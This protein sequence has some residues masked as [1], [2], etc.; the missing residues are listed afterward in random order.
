MRRDL[1]K[2]RQTWPRYFP[3]KKLNAIDVRVNA[4]DPNWPII[5]V[6]GPIHVNPKF[7]S[8]VEKKVIFPLIR[9]ASGLRFLHR[10][11]C[12]VKFG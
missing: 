3:V 11:N 1:F 12:G 5:G 7:I 2:L 4:M 9:G 10:I 6:G 8:Q